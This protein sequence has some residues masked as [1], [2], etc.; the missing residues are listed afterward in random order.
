ME[1]RG[2]VRDIS[3]GATRNFRTWS[4]VA[5]FMMAQVDENEALDAGPAGPSALERNM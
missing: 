1:Y 5:D 4:D 3:S 2:N